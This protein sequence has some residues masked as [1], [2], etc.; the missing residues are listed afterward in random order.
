MSINLSFFGGAGTVTGSRY[1]I[2]SGEQNILIDCGLFQGLKDLRL[3]NWAPFPVSPKSIDA[4]V[5]THAH[6]DHSGYLPAVVRDGYRGSIHCS[7]A[8]SDICG[9]LLPDSAHLLEQDAEYANRRGYSKHK[10]ALPLYTTEDAEKAL[11][12]FSAAKFGAS[13]KLGGDASFTLRRTGHILGASSVSLRTSE[14][15]IVFS[16]DLGRYND[17]TMLDPEPVEDADYIVV[18]STYGNRRHSGEEPRKILG[19]IIEK[20]VSRGGTVVIPAFAVGRAQTLLYHL[21]RLKA[22]GRIR[23]VPIYLNSPMAMDASEIWCNN[24][25]DQKLEAHECRRACAVAHYIR[26]VEESKALN[27]NPMPKVIVSASG[28]ATGGRVLHHIKRFGPD[29]RSTILF[30][31]YQAAGT[32]GAAMLAGQDAVKIYGEYVPIRAQIANLD[33]LS[34]HGDADEIMRWLANFKRKP[35]TCF[36]THGEPEAA[37]ALAHRIEGDLGWRCKVP[38]IMDEVVLS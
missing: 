1:L 33:M 15:T 37:A 3:R 14:R 26:S 19:D 13:T 27:E 5:L 36:I 10:P 6:L 30:A 9:I 35:K 23:N 24:H 16:G 18:E 11:R 38:E 22:A 17:E 21:E 2:Q 25:D 31:G 20:T 29:P 34:A 12:K 7:Q 4:L 32:R 8:T 28:M